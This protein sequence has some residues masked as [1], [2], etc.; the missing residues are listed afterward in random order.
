[1]KRYLWFLLVFIFP[2]SS[3]ADVTFSSTRAYQSVSLTGSA[4]IPNVLLGSNLTL[5]L[6]HG[7]CPCTLNNMTNIYPGQFGVVHIINSSSGSEILTLSGSQYSL[8]V[9]PPFT[10]D[11][12]S[13]N[14]WFYTVNADSKVLF[15]SAALPPSISNTQANLLSG[16]DG[17]TSGWTAQNATLATGATCTSPIGGTNTC[18][19]LTEDTTTNTHFAF[20]NTTLPTSTNTASVFAKINSGTRFVEF[21][22]ADNSFVNVA[23]EIFDP[24]TCSDTISGTGA[25]TIGTAVI[26]GHGTIARSNGFC[27]GWIQANLGGAVPVFENI[28][29]ATPAGDNYLGTGQS[30]LL[31]RPAVRNCVCSPP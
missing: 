19:L 2:A 15:T 11:P 9:T 25:T 27:E 4:F 14:D 28:Q 5:T 3:M 21:R 26:I 10:P 1:M 23:S 30:N 20:Q 22:I 13:E 17:M 8:T 12:A 6:V 7:T 31:W 16:A 24:V 18:A 29:L